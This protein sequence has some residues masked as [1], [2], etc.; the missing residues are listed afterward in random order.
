MGDDLQMLMNLEEE[1]RLMYVAMT[2]AVERHFSC[3][4]GQ[5]YL[6]PIL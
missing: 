5:S 6:A 3:A 1:R 4:L 2:G